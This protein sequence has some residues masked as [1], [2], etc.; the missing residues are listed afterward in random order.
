MPAGSQLDGSGPV[1]L[2]LNATWPSDNPELAMKDDMPDA[3][4]TL[5]DARVLHAATFAD[6]HAAI[7]KTVRIVGHPVN[8]K[9]SPR[10]D[11]LEGGS[12]YCHID[13]SHWPAE[14]DGKSIEVIGLVTRTAGHS[15][16][17]ATRD[18]D[19]SWS[20]GVGASA[21]QLFSSTGLT[22]PDIELQ[23]QIVPGDIV[24][25]ATSHSECP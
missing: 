6:L 21:P 3:P 2:R 24:L 7:G 19:G 4:S 17:I 16:P 18:Q 1:V 5:A 23:R 20:Q 14:Y 11:L 10:L 9:A 13:A 12:V 8:T 22:A 25:R 15:F